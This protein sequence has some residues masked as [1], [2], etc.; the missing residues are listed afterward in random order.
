MTPGKDIRMSVI[1][2]DKPKGPTSFSV[3]EKVSEILGIC[4]SGHAGT[5]DPNATGLLLIALGEARKAMPVL[6]GLDKEY[7]GTMLLHD[8]VSAGAVRKALSGFRGTIK[9]VPPVKSAVARKERE[10]KVHEIEVLGI[11]GREVE[12]RVLCEAGTYIRKIAHD[13]GEKLGCGAHLKDLRRTKVGPFSIDSA[14]TMPE[15]ERMTK[16]AIEPF[17]VHLEEALS[18]IGLP[19]ITIRDEFEKDVRRGSPIRKSFV[20]EVTGSPKKG[21]YAY[22]AN[23]EWDIVALATF[24]GS[25]TSVAKT[26]RVFL[27]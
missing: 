13:A 10:R 23:E 24:I 22:V 7:T 11:D 21:E 1:L 12:F 25:G 26:D 14:V 6:S 27:A 4:K 16:R 20:K 2:V 19:K 15:L 8:D 9:Q 3:V 5:L 18:M 17:T